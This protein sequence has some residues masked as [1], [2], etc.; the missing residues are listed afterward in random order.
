MV[1]LS[2]A[3][4][5]ASAALAAQSRPADD[6]AFPHTKSYGRATIQFQDDTLHMVALYDYSQRNHDGAWLVLQ[7]G[8][9]VKE[10]TTVNRSNF[11]IRT[12]E[13]RTVPSPGSANHR[14]NSP[15][16]LFGK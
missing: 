3:V 10:R 14:M 7:T 5:V 9:A 15:S 6:N 13:G 1:R 11:H 12:P 4:L 16:A 8:V 2:I